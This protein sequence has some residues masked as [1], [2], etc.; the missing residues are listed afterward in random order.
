MRYGNYQVSLGPS[1]TPVVRMLIIANGVLLL[2]QGLIGWGVVEIFGLT[3]LDIT[4]RFALWQLVTYL[5]LHANFWPHLFFNMLTLWMFGSDLEGRWGGSYFLKYYF[6]TGVGAGVCSVL[7]HPFS[8]TP[9]IGASGAVYGILLAYAVLF[10][11]RYVYIYFLIPI[12]VKYLVGIMAVLGVM[13]AMTSPGDQID[14]FAH[15]GGM[16]V[17]FL[18]LK[19]WFRPDRLRESYL[20]WRLRR[21]RGKFKVYES[22]R[23]DDYIH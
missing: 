16:L 12:R 9:S 13:S 4:T 11:N 22:Q 8:P 1:L 6:I 15:L 2:V 7:A 10:P 23:D 17:G 19:G 5:F 21:L 3:P 14:H 20:R 18:F